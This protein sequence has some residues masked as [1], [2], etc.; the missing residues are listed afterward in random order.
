[1]KLLLDTHVLLWWWS[2]N[3]S[4]SESAYSAI[5][6]DDNLVMISAV[7]MWELATKYRIG[8]LD[9]AERAITQY[10]SMC[11]LDGFVQL[12]ITWQH[13]RLSGSF[14]MKHAD[15]FDRMLAAQ[16]QLESA[17]LVTQ[18]AAFGAFNIQT[19]W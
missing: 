12:P 8:K 18:D 1:M 4:L 16:A 10:E 2:K 19:L 9:L 6:S 14:A 11:E 13:S 7:S 15:P 17:V 5:D 3:P